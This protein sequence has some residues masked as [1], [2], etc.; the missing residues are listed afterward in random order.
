MIHEPH[1]KP[2][3]E[4]EA[5]SNPKQTSRAN[6]KYIYIYI[7]INHIEEEKIKEIL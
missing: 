2:Q 7:Y 3:G 5:N 1:S 4:P 6:F